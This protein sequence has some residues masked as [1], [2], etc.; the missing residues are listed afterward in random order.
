MTAAGQIMKGGT[1]S[2]EHVMTKVKFGRKADQLCK[3]IFRCVEAASSAL[4]CFKRHC[5]LCPAAT[6]AFRA[7]VL[8]IHNTE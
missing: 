7:P 3:P 2:R 5:W 4:S 6:V 8:P 1:M